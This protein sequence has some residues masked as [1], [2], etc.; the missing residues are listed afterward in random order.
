MAERQ[1]QIL[2]LNDLQDRLNQNLGPNSLTRRRRYQT[3]EQMIYQEA[4]QNALA[5]EFRSRGETTTVLD[6]TRMEN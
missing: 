3:D 4:A 1:G 2:Q 6:L 5:I